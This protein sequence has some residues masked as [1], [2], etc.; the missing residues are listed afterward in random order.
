MSSFLPV[1]AQTAPDSSVNSNVGGRVQASVAVP[2]MAE[3]GSAVSP[4]ADTSSLPATTKPLLLDRLSLINPTGWNP[5]AVQ[6]FID[7]A[8]TEPWIDAPVQALASALIEPEILSEYGCT[9]ILRR[10]YQRGQRRIIVEVLEFKNS[11]GAYGAYGLLRKGSTTYISRGDASSED[12]QS[13]SFWK[14]R[15]FV[16]IVGTSEDDDESKGVVRVVADS[17][18]KAIDGNSGLPLIISRLPVLER[19]RG[20][21]K[22]VMGPVGARRF[23][24]APLIT[25]LNWKQAVAGAVA[26]YQTQEPYRERLKLLLVDYGNRELAQHAF[27]SYASQIEAEHPRLKTDDPARTY[28]FKMSGSFLLCQLHGAAVI[29]I[30]GAR[31]RQ[32]AVMMGQYF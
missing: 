13:I 6:T 16:R 28:L 14:S 5:S 8:K 2:P 12:D 17:L 1:I 4:P 11:S 26:D 24:E 20:T 23:F 10:T 21:E 32:S 27:N 7:G 15:F 3:V 30:T 29:V 19:V 18:V 9:S 31:K 25:T 22:L